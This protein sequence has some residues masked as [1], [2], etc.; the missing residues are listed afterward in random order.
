LTPPQLP[1]SLHFPGAAAQPQPRTVR[2]VVSAVLQH[3]RRSHIKCVV[4]AECPVKFRVL[5]KSRDLKFS[6]RETKFSKINI[7][8]LVSSHC[9]NGSV[10]L[11][12]LH[13]CNIP[14]RVTTSAHSAT[15]RASDRLSRPLRTLHIF[16]IVLYCSPVCDVQGLHTMVDDCVFA[17]RA[18]VICSPGRTYPYCRA[19][20]NSAFYPPWDSF[21]A[22]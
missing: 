2:S 22:T 11:Y 14:Q 7:P 15:A 16:I 13:L 19:E 4:H 17:R 5:N 8:I 9:Q 12:S 20:V 10:L 18:I 3:S 1:L 21:W 6:Y